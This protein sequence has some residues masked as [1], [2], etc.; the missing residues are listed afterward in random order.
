MILNEPLFDNRLR[1]DSRMI[2]P[3]NPTH[4]LTA[5]H[6]PSNNGILQS[7]RAVGRV[8]YLDAGGQRVAEMQR[9]RNIGRGKH[10]CPRALVIIFMLLVLCLVDA[11]RPVRV[12][13]LFHR[14]LRVSNARG[15]GVY[16]VIAV[17]QRSA[18]LY[19]R[20][21]HTLRRCGEAPHGS[22]AQHE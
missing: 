20:C 10:H 3:G 19:W 1:G 12:P 18:R 11:V 8:T 7:R 14:R 4:T 6:S 5:H 21:W 9:S 2:G 13:S 17:C 15:C 22:N 16:R